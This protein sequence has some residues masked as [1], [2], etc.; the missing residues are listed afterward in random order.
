MNTSILVAAISVG[1]MLPM[2]FAL[3][4]DEARQYFRLVCPQ[5]GRSRSRGGNFLHTQAICRNCKAAWE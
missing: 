3:G 1:V 5:C 4:T 2:F